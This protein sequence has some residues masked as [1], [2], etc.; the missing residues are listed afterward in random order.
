MNI[1][2]NNTFA[3]AF[4]DHQ[5]DWGSPYRAQIRQGLFDWL[6]TKVT[7]ADL[8]QI[9]IAGH[10]RGGCLAL[11]LIKEFR[12][13]PG[14]QRGENLGGAHRRDV[15]RWRKWDLGMVQ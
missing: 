8:K 5:Y 6:K 1:N 9:I 11:G 3:V 4:P 15:P 14:L 2:P 13:R 7:P 12:A 10:S